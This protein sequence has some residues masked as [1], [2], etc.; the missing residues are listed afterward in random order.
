LL[1]SAKFKKEFEISPKSVCFVFLVL[2][3][4]NGVASFFLLT[5]IFISIP[6]ADWSQ[7]EGLAGCG[8]SQ[9]AHVRAYYLYCMCLAPTD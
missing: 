8:R 9:I 6:V 4:V 7:A 5:S 2:V 1:K 3:P